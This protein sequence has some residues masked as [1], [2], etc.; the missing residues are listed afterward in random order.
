[1]NAELVRVANDASIL[2]WVSSSAASC[3]CDYTNE[4]GVDREGVVRLPVRPFGSRVQ[5]LESSPS[6]RSS[7]LTGRQSRSLTALASA[8]Q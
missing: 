3:V 5:N 8:S 7:S 1:M 2:K 6:S 4:G